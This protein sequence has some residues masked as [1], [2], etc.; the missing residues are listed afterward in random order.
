MNHDCVGKLNAV[1]AFRVLSVMYYVEPFDLRH[2]NHVK[3]ENVLVL[4]PK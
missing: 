1:L 4:L 2:Q 3:R